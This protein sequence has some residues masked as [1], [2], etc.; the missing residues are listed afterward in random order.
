MVFYCDGVNMPIIVALTTDQQQAQAFINVIQRQ[1]QALGGVFTQIATWVWANPT[2]TPQQAFDAFGTNATSLCVLANAYLALLTAV[3][4][5]AASPV[6]AGYSLTMN[7][8]GTVTV[9]PP[10]P[11]IPLTN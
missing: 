3:G 5:P 1:W 11:V 9:V 4:A 6:P 10:A 8:D 2:L 7:A